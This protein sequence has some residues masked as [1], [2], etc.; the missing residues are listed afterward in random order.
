ML[1]IENKDNKTLV[2]L[3]KPED[4]S[5]GLDFITSDDQ[6][7]QVGTWWYD[8][9]KVLDRHYHNILDRRSDLTQECVTIMHGSMLVKV[10]DYDQNYLSKFIMEQGDFALFLGGGHEYTILEN[11]TRIIETKNGPFL[12]VQ[13]DKTRF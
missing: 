12:G 6:Y 4:W 8:E 2:V 7:L 5:K 11:D 9:G 1:Q 13:L 3:I 10:Y